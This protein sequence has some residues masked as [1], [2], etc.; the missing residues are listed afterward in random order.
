MDL[1]GDK[2]NSTELAILIKYGVT[3]S[4][5]DICDFL[6]KK[7]NT[8]YTLISDGR[9]PIESER[10]VVRDAKRGTR[11]YDFRAVAKW[12]NEVRENDETK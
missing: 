4:D 12:W 5:D 10:V 11:L 9:L 6:K 1:I 3:L 8:F 7:K 2:F